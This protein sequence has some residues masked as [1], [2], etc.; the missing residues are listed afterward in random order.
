MH[1]HRKRAG[2]DRACG[3]A[4][5]L[6][7]GAAVLR[8]L[9]LPASIVFTSFIGALFSK[10][11]KKGR[12]LRA[13]KKYRRFGKKRRRF[14]FTKNGAVQTDQ[15]SAVPKNMRFRFVPNILFFVTATVTAFHNAPS[16][17]IKPR[18]GSDARRKT[19]FCSS[20]EF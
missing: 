15:R 10:G 18:I 19:D 8:L 12:S 17:K 7:G 3:R 20:S 2:A 16:Q 9:L 1:A 13:A 4:A 6:R 5:P 14:A 11:H